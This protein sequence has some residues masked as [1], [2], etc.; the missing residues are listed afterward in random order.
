VNIDVTEL[1]SSLSSGAVDGQENPVNI[2]R[3]FNLHDVQ[4][5]VIE[6]EHIIHTTPLFTNSDW[7]SNLDSQAQ[8]IV[9]EAATEAAQWDARTIASTEKEATEFLKDNGMTFVGTDGCLNLDAFKESVRSHVDAAF[10]EMAKTAKRIE[11]L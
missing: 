6:T 11:E 7:W 10:P 4:K 9:Q 8:K 5:Y 3:S 2:I 1:V